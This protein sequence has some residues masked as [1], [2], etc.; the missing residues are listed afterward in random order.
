MEWWGTGGMEDVAHYGLRVL[1]SKEYKTR[2]AG[3]LMLDAR[4]WM[5]DKRIKELGN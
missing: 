3:C 2:N 5:K 1:R 4:C